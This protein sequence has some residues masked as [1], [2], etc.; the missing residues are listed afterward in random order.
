[1]NTKRINPYIF[2]LLQKTKAVTYL[3]KITIILSFVICKLLLRMEE[4]LRNKLSQQMLD[5][6]FFPLLYS[7]LPFD[8]MN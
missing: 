3:K 7:S 1:M 2:W 5:P 6:P 8:V 4:K